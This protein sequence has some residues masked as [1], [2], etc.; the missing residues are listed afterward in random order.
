M[1]PQAP[2][3]LYQW[4][5]AQML[6]GK[7]SRSR[8]RFMKIVEPRLQE[9]DKFR[10]DLLEKHAEKVKETV[11]GQEVEKVVYLDKDGKDTTDKAAG[12]KFKI[13]DVPAFDKEY[14]EYLQENYVIDVTPA[15][16]ET[17]YGVRNILLNTTEEFSGTQALVYDEWCQAFENIAKAPEEDE[18]I[19][20][21]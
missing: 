19:G 7:D 5:A 14:N 18:S 6:H 8:T 11:E 1:V 13:A 12:V 21:A 9:V 2:L 15:V 16:I 4:L 17:I 10:Q 3:S 20:R